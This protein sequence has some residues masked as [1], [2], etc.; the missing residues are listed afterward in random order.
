MATPQADARGVPPAWL[1]AAL[2]GLY[3]L[4][5]GVA[6]L[7]FAGI[8]GALFIDLVSREFLGRGVFGAQ[9]FA[10]Y[11]MVVVAFLGFALA[12]GWRAHLGIEVAD[13]LAPRAW[14]AAMERLADFVAAAGCLFLAYWSW[15]FVL[16]SF[17]DGSRGQALE[18]LQWPVQSVLVWCFVS[19]AVRYLAFGWYP[20]L[21]PPP[22][23]PRE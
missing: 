11:C 2:R 1:P 8:T 14:N 15:R 19:S 16:G 12:V 6:I 10:A 20:A 17:R 23:E 9:R 3:R 7:G 22:E 21:R 18:I 13:R 4:E 5:A